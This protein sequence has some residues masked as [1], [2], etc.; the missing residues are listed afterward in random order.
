MMWL[1]SRLAAEFLLNA[2][3]L[4]G[5]LAACEGNVG[6]ML[7]CWAAMGTFPIWGKEINTR[8]MHKNDRAQ[9]SWPS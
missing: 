9:G 2:V 1:R 3:A 6:L 7:G 5:Y 8:D 4:L